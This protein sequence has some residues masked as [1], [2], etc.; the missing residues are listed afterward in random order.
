MKN[1]SIGIIGFGNI[2]KKRYYA[3]TKIKNYKINIK[4]IVDI[5]K[6]NIRDKEIR[7]FRNWKEIKNI[8]VD[9]IIISTPTKISEI[10]SQQL[11]GKYHL[12]IEKP[13]TTNLEIMKKLLIIS[14]KNNKVLKTGYNLRFDNGLKIVKKK[15]KEKIIGKIYYC[16]LIYANGTARSNTNAVGSLVDMGTHAINLIEWFFE[17]PIIKLNYCQNQKNEFLKKKK[18]DNGFC[19]F[20][21]NKFSCLIHHGFC[22]WKNKFLLEIYGSKGFIE[23]DSLPKWG[24]QVITIGLRTYPSGVPKVEKKIFKKDYSWVN[25]ISTTLDLIS[26]KKKGI[27]QFN[28]EGLVTLK[29]TNKVNNS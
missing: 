10:I 23:V 17:K 16:K 4:Y 22:N 5:N 28:S 2:G 14:N 6:E 13:I 29:N 26:Y 24:K 1:I 11:V 7:W 18:I 27:T 19:L 25:E 8:D 12:L 9:L 20:K 3:L 21:V 15:L